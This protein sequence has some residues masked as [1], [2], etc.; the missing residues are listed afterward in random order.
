ME[1]E[2]LVGDLVCDASMAAV[3]RVVTNVSRYRIM[4][5]FVRALAPEYVWITGVRSAR[6]ST[7]RPI[8]AMIVIALAS[9]GI[10]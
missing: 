6:K 8:P 7:L 5:Q 9:D 3:W 1:G 2:F 10:M 4:V